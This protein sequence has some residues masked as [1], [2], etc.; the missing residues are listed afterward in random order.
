MHISLIKI[1]LGLFFCVCTAVYFE[2][3]A[4][5]VAGANL[6]GQRL[7]FIFATFLLPKS[8]VKLTST[9]SFYHAFYTLINVAAVY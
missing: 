1:V 2:K 5:C 6:K 7:S 3:I 8:T 9:V 4:I